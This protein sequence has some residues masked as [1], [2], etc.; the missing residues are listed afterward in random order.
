[1]TD[2]IQ[3]FLHSL[4]K[5]TKAKLEKRLAQLKKSPFKGNDIK[6]LKGYN[7]LYRLRLGKIRIIYQIANTNVEIID[8]DYRGNI[9]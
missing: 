4:D 6:K 2:K 8:I 5:K 7:N 1:M 9:Y 3:K